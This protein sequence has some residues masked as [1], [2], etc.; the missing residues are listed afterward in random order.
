MIDPDDELVRGTLGL[1]PPPSSGRPVWC[2]VR[3][4]GAPTCSCKPRRG[5]RALGNEGQHKN[6]SDRGSDAE[7]REWSVIACF[8][9]FLTPPPRT[10]RTFP[11]ARSDGLSDGRG[12]RHE[13][14]MVFCCYC[15]R[16]AAS[17]PS[18]IRQSVFKSCCPGGSRS[19]PYFF[20]ASSAPQ[21]APRARSGSRAFGAG[22][23][24][25]FD[26]A[27]EIET[28]GTFAAASAFLRGSC[29][30]G[31]CASQLELAASGLVLVTLSLSLSLSLSSIR[32][33]PLYCS[34]A[35]YPLTASDRGLLTRLE[36]EYGVYE[37]AGET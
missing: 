12:G 28:K 2:L 34:L 36:L 15:H 31:R 16:L 35:L 21:V 32:D 5:L 24:V 17:P 3:V 7:R 26:A 33:G 30:R 4:R 29:G 1:P 18:L 20:G 23:G 19:D 14:A 37:N 6:P 8:A 27:N 25:F 11:L 13:R 22:A 9:F 10:S